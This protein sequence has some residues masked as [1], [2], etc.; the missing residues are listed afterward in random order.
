MISVLLRQFKRRAIKPHLDDTMERARLLWVEALK[1]LPMDE[2]HKEK[3]KKHWRNLQ[4][5]FRIESGK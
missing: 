1:D 2:M 3:L 5:D 4:A